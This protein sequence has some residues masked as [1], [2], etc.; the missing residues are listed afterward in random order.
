[1]I[2]SV[3]QSVVRPRV[4]GRMQS[5]LSRRICMNLTDEWKRPIQVGVPDN[6]TN[7][8]YA[9]GGQRSTRGE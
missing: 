9:G 7:S 1:M 5:I 2:E 6:R 3:K 4:G 8:E